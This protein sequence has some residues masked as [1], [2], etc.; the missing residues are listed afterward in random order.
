MDFLLARKNYLLLLGGVLFLLIILLFFALSLLFPSS[1]QKPT[2]V[3]PPPQT[4]RLPT[5][6]PLPTDFYSKEYQ[7]SVEKIN[8]EQEPLLK[9]DLLVSRFQDS[10]PY[11][12]RYIFVTYNLSLNE[13]VVKRDPNQKDAADAEFDALLKKNNIDSRAWFPSLVVE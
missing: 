5:V 2:E 4:Q 1:S 6:E 13:V 9:Q 11:S 3:S 7:Q 8:K 12:G 10:L